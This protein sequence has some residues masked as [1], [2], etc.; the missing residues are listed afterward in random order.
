MTRDAMLEQF[1]AND[2][3]LWWMAA[4]SA[5][6]FVGTLIVVPIL[7]IRI[8]ED[9]FLPRKRH[10]SHWRTLHPVPGVAL[11]VA[12]NAC[13]VFFVL[14][15]VAMLVLP[16]QGILTI[17][18]GIMLLNFPGKYRLE[19]RIARLR[20]VSRSINW[21]RG[22]AGRPPLRVPSESGDIDA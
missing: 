19:R 13:G 14:A 4:G 8:P 15:G 20:P 1:R 7:V 12:K 9:Y 16:G 2:G 6:T 17:L 11:L 3:L 22:H 5:V 18:V 21:L 10:R